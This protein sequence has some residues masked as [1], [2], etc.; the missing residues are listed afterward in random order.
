MTKY[1]T[2][3][4]SGGDKAEVDRRVAELEGRG[5]E[6]V[7]IHEDSETRKMFT[8][9]PGAYGPKRKFVNDFTTHKYVAVMRRANAGR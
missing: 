6:L 3:R 1:F 2:T 5:F 8:L 9:D 4:V 7:G